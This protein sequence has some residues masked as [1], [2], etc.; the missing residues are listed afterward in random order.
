MARASVGVRGSDSEKVK[1]AGFLS[2][3][4]QGLW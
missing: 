3:Q 2:R 1:T 4:E